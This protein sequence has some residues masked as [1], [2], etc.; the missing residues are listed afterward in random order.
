MC[1]HENIMPIVETNEKDQKVVYSTACQDCF[2][3]FVVSPMTLN[4][5]FMTNK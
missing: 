3:E 4:E 1:E 5:Y 2:R